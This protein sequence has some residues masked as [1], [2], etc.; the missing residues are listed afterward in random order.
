MGAMNAVISIFVLPSTSSYQA[1]EFHMDLLPID[2]S[3]VSKVS[4]DKIY[5]NRSVKVAELVIGEKHIDGAIAFTS[6]SLET[7]SGLL[8]GIREKLG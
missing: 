5:K 4:C 3:N 7:E 6:M 2:T 8:P 1:L